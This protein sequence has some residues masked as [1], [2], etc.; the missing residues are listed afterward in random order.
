M[1]EVDFFGIPRVGA[2]Q[3]LGDEANHH[4]DQSN[5]GPGGNQVQAGSLD[6]ITNSTAPFGSPSKAQ[7]LG[8]Q[9]L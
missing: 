9:K 7:P 3:W 4:D 2:H 5:V 6:L 8:A 1:V